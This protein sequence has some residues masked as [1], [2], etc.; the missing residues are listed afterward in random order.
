MASLEYSNEAIN[1]LDM[2]HKVNYIVYVEGVDDICFWELILE[3]YSD[4]KF[5]IQEVGGCEKLK[6]YIDD[7]ISGDLNIIVATDFDFNLFS[8][9]TVW[10]K[11]ILRTYGYSIEN[12]FINY[13][14]I[15]KVIKALGKLKDRELTGINISRW[16][17]KTHEVMSDLIK[18]DIYNHIFKCGNCVIGD[19]AHKFLENKKSISLSEGLIQSC[20]EEIMSLI[21]EY[22]ESIIN[23]ILHEKRTETRHWMKGHFLFSVVANYIRLVLKGLGKN[24]SISDSALYSSFI[25]TYEGE[26]NKSNVENN[27]YKEIASNVS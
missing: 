25:L 20:M 2:F 19:T 13:I 8:N 7:V 18:L 9:E 6:E 15:R 11:R 16:L 12:T 23:D 4:L 5:E 27:Y 17:E 10:H 22:D 1:I 24:I 3:K 26:L 14:T 21:E